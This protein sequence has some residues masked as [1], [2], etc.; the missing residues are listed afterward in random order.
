MS[1]GSICTRVAVTVS[2]AA[3]IVEAAKLMREA[4]VGDLIVVDSREG[5]RAPVGILTD[6]DIVVGVVA[7]EARPADLTV[8][9]VMQS[10]LFVAQED[11]EINAVLESMHR[12]GVRRAPVVAADGALIGVLSIDDVI[13]HLG[14]QLG[15][16][17]RLIH[18]E[19]QR[20]VLTRP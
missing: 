17:S 14:E 8:T 11:D 12:K 7:K 19:Q 5:V 6:R 18:V 3:G 10:Q 9:D 15:H 20:E 2:P 13:S 16:I 4:H 1:V